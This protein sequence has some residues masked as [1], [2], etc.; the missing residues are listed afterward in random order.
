MIDGLP[1]EEL[2]HS[3]VIWDHGAVLGVDAGWSPKKP[4]TGLCLIEWSNREIDIRCCQARADED[5][6][7]KKLDQLIQRRKLLCVGIDGPL[8]PGLGITREY[9][10]AEALLSGGKFQ[11]R[12]KPGAINSKIGQVLHKQATELAK[13]TIRSQDIAPAAYPYRIHHKAVIEAFPN[14]SL[15]VLHPDEGFPVQSQVKRR[16]TDI[17]FPALT[18]K[19]TRLLRTLLPEYNFDL[20]H[21]HGHEVIA[22]FVCA[23]TALCVVAGRCVAVG[24]QR[25]GHIVLPP[26][27]FWG[28]SKT[29][30][31][32]WARD[33][34]HDNWISLRARFR[35]A[36]LYKDDKPWS[37]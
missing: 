14:T 3:D 1:G 22:S 31:N 17:L 32:K 33:A 2:S 35:N 28:T 19:I 10:A 36:E 37:P 8:I 34:L 29:G 30:S 24:D 27:E 25:L 12:G 20:D 13:L 4:T 11:K 5:D 23:C 26:L 18:R 15:A 7:L 6:R 9:R 21:I 16:W